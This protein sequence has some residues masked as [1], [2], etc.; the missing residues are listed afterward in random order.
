MREPTAD[1]RGLPTLAALGDHGVEADAGDERRRIGEARRRAELPEQRGGG[2]WT[3]PGDRLQQVG[4][5]RSRAGLARGQPQILK[6]AN[7]GD[8][9][10]LAN[11]E[12]SVA[13][14]SGRGAHMSAS[15]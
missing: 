8:L 2:V 9:S 4:I 15:A 7:P 11:A 6:G 5:G 12:Q 13:P 14:R 10:G 3:D 1:K